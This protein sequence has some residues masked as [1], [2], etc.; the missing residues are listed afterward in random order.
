VCDFV[1]FVYI[2]TVTFLGVVIDIFASMDM[3]TDEEMVT[4]FME[5]DELHTGVKVTRRKLIHCSAYYHG[6]TASGMRDAGVLRLTVP[7]ISRMALQTVA[8]FIDA[9]DKKVVLP[10]SLHTLEEV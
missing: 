1:K 5:D 9:A 7:D 8:D 10:T 4:L 2:I 3:S 6:L